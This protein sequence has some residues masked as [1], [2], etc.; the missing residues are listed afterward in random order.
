MGDGAQVSHPFNKNR[1]HLTGQ[2]WG[3]RGAAPEGRLRMAE[4]SDEAMERARQRLLAL[5]HPNVA[6]T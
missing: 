2:S 4:A 3:R 6:V 1:N 5:I